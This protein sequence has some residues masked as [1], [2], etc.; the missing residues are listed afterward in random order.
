MT[1]DNIKDD[2]PLASDSDPVGP[3]PGKKKRKKRFGLFFR[4][5]TLTL[6]LVVLIPVS[7]YFLSMND[8]F[9]QWAVQNIVA[10]VNDNLEAKIEVGDID[11]FDP[12][13]LRLKEVYVLAANDTLAGISDIL[14]D[15]QAQPLLDSKAIVNT[16]EISNGTIKLLRDRDSIWN[17]S[18]IAAPSTSTDT[19]TS[20]ASWLIEVDQLLLNNISFTYRDSTQLQDDLGTNLIRDRYNSMN[21]IDFTLDDLY[22]RGSNISAMIGEQ[23]YKI[24][25]SH[26]KFSDRKSPAKVQNLD[27]D[28]TLDEDG[29]TAEDTDVLLNDA[30][31]KF[32]ASISDYNVFAG[33]DFMSADLMLNLV[34]EDIDGYEVAG[35]APMPIKLAR[36]AS[37]NIDVSGRLD[38]IQIQYLDI[39]FAKTTLH[40]NGLLRDVTNP[41]KLAYD[42]EIGNS[43]VG[44]EDLRY[45]DGLDLRSV[46]SFGNAN[47]KQLDVNGDLYS[48]TAEAAISASPGSFR[49][50]LSSS[51]ANQISYSYNGSIK[52]VDLAQLTGNP[53]IKSDINGRLIAEGKGVNLNRITAD[54]SFHGDY[55]RINSYTFDSLAL[56]ASLQ[57]GIANLRKLEITQRNTKSDALLGED[58]VLS[59][60]GQLDLND[61]NDP[62]YNLEA[63]IQALDLRAL[64]EVPE[65]PSYITARTKIQ[66]SGFQLS[67]IIGELEASIDLMIFDDRAILPFD[68]IMSFENVDEGKM[69]SLESDF[70]SIY[71]EGNFEYEDL[72]ETI[73]IHSTQLAGYAE[74][75]LNKIITS[76]QNIDKGIEEQSI[77]VLEKFPALDARIF[78]E[79]TD[80]SPLSI[81]LD[82]TNVYSSININLNLKNS[83]SLSLLTIDSI[84][85]DKLGVN[86]NDLELITKDLFM[87]GELQMDIR[88]NEPVFSSFLLNTDAREPLTINNN[89]FYNTFL[90]S[91]LAD[92][93]LAIS[94]HIDMNNEFDISVIGD[95]FVQDDILDMQLTVL[96][97]GYDSLHIWKNTKDIYASFGEKGFNIDT[98]KL[99]RK[100]K[101]IITLDGSY[102]AFSDNFQNV[103]LTLTG[104]DFAYVRELLPSLENPYLDYMKGRVDTL[105]I[106]LDGTMSEPE[107]DLLFS[108][109]DLVFNRIPLGNIYAN[110]EHSDATISGMI[111]TETKKS[112]INK[113]E[114]IINSIPYSL[115]LEDVTNRWHK[116]KQLDIDISIDSLSLAVLDPFVDLMNQSTGYVNINAEIDG[117]DI[118]DYDVRGN[119]QYSNI[120]TTVNP[121]NIR[122]ISNADINFSEDK[123]EFSEFS[124]EN[125]QSELPGSKANITGNLLLDNFVPKQLDLNLD[126]DRLKILGSKSKETM[127]N[128]YGDLVISTGRNGVDIQ[129]KVQSPEIEGDIEILRSNL[130]LPIDESRELAESRF[131]YYW[132]GDNIYVVMVSD[133][134]TIIE[135]DEKTTPIYEAMKLDLKIYF[136]ADLVVNIDINEVMSVEAH[137][138]TRLRGTNVIFQ[139]EPYSRDSKLLGD[140]Y[141][142]DKS[143]L[144]FAG[145][146][147]ET[148]GKIS[149]PTGNLEN[150]ELDISAIY[151]GRL[152]S[153]DNSRDFTVTIKVNGTKENPIIT[154]GYT[155]GG[156]VNPQRSESTLNDVL[157]LIVLGTLP[158]GS[159]NGGS[160][161]GEG[162]GSSAGASLINPAIRDVLGQLAGSLDFLDVDVSTGGSVDNTTVKL[163][164]KIIDGVYIAGGGGLYG[165]EIT[166]EVPL[167]ELLDKDFAQNFRLQFTQYFNDNNINATT[168]ERINS[169]F[170]LRWAK[171]W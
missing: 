5:V 98:L 151:E 129:G 124:I 6:G 57:E 12:E 168:R 135:S 127:P 100:D 54:I 77:G 83:D 107:I 108:T 45:I 22:L 166:I 16:L 2:T 93:T 37:I 14:I 33:D 29:I 95:M 153:T 34:A 44:R 160:N 20:S 131:N 144:T 163:R 80:L 90:Y 123:I 106:R 132:E 117:A 42:I 139:K 126:I 134:L 149:F 96:E 19:S 17:F 161:L 70:M 103:N 36:K 99:Q 25:L 46:P 154:Y 141:L 88:N 51:W 115:A 68:I 30:I 155:I 89:T 125:I 145:R 47:L 23:I 156:E 147:F 31:I 164:G 170:K 138:G 1:E 43:I 150:P 116:R 79:I 11:F 74:A 38:S 137:I 18:R 86:R 111:Q 3:S 119:L 104:F 50:K 110:L 143:V 69:L 28:F 35:F 58:E 15:F 72:I 55:N 133:S 152:S 87:S 167:A 41:E 27:G 109:K 53:S 81:F 39:N 148:S 122:Y 92:D 21:Y 40:L 113:C 66:G 91:Q 9:R 140:I 4:L 82:S 75:Q 118:T 48:V 60:S 32:D 7:L 49:G 158:G 112:S 56:D 136:P 121:V 63:Q 62:S 59:L 159:E 64:L 120:K 171:T 24:D 128:L 52:N 162:L 130:T 67:N 73:I 169:E 26:L 157:S 105:G 114:V 8:S 97:L 94:S 142:Q 61:L 102:D 78:G 146:E 10:I 65:A 101:E 85:I 13:G 76:T 165:G 71:L 84:S